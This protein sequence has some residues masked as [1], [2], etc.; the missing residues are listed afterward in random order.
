MRLSHAV[1]LTLLA[2]AAFVNT[3]E[4]TLLID[5][6]VT[7]SVIGAGQSAMLTLL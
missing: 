2:S 3:A 7:P 5:F 4:A 6:S 1:T